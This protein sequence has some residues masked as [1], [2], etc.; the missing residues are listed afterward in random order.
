MLV[1]YLF[2]FHF[3]SNWCGRRIGSEFAGLIFTSNRSENSVGFFNPNSEA[4][5]KKINVGIRPNGLAFDDHRGLLL[6]AMLAT[7]P[8]LLLSLWHWWM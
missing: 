7:H 1:R 6:S 4:T 5:L 3:K 8:S 2:T